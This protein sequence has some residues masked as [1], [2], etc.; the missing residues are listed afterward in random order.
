[1]KEANK[2]GLWLIELNLDECY[3]ILRCSHNTKE[4]L[5]TALSLV[6]EINGINVILTP[7]K[8]AGTIRSLKD[9]IKKKNSL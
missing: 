8:T 3:G 2:I 1:M 4:T 9:K 6:R 5:I 7:F